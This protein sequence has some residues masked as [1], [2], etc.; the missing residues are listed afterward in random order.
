MKKIFT[1]I[2]LVIA[3]SILLSSCNSGKNSFFS[4]VLSKQ[5]PNRLFVDSVY[6]KI[7][8]VD[9]HST[10]YMSKIKGLMYE[11]FIPPMRKEQN[12]SS[13]SLNE[14]IMFNGSGLN[15][16]AEERLLFKEYI[17]SLEMKCGVFDYGE[18]ETG[19]DSFFW[20]L[21]D[22]IEMFKCADQYNVEVKKNTGLKEYVKEQV[23]NFSLNDSI[24]KF[25]AVFY[26]ADYLG[27]SA[28]TGILNEYINNIFSKIDDRGAADLFNDIDYY[29]ISQ[30]VDLYG[31]NIKLPHKIKEYILS[32]LNFYYNN[33]AYLY[34]S[35]A[36]LKNFKELGENE[37]A[38]IEKYL[39]LIDDE[40]KL[41]DGNYS[42]ILN[43]SFSM[44]ATCSAVYISY[45]F[46]E[47]LP[48]KEIIKE[49]VKLWYENEE[50][51][52]YNCEDLYY[53]YM[54]SLGLEY[55]TGEKIRA[56]LPSFFS[57]HD[58][59]KD[60]V[61]ELFYCGELIKS[62]DL[63]VPEA[64][65]KTYLKY[66][67]LYKSRVEDFGGTFADV[68]RLIILNGEDYFDTGLDLTYYNEYIDGY[69]FNNGTIVDIFYYCVLGEKSIVKNAS[70]TDALLDGFRRKRGFLNTR[71][72][73]EYNMYPSLLGLESEA[74]LEG[75]DIVT[76]Y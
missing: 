40:Y 73:K 57:Q 18:S 37:K 2:A 17:D 74:L 19:T 24:T 25:Y 43:I 7:N 35:V 54:L 70:G 67:E 64:L 65:R 41:E 51:R 36:T 50:Y 39:K 4:E 52:I 13:F 56:Y 1:S 5:L 3:L 33:I 8:N 60:S 72:D 34:A 44:M 27:V 76:V 16:S 61:R 48:D 46:E 58:F 66:A 42:T 15:M 31:L 14:V 62:L 53:Y 22:T 63:E 45:L 30:I 6:H 10:S 68:A 29:N 59:E 12:L 32:D 75:K 11:D 47:E 38:E 20:S 28:D 71:L 55:D 49:Y 21:F 69:N 23:G 9:L 26:A